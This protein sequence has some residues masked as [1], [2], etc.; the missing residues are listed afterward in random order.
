MSYWPSCS[1][2]LTKRD[3]MCHQE[4]GICPARGLLKC[5]PPKENNYGAGPA[6]LV[7]LRCLAMCPSPDPLLELLKACRLFLLCLSLPSWACALQSADS[8]SSCSF[9]VSDYVRHHADG[10]PTGLRRD[11]LS[12]QCKAYL[13][14][15]GALPEPQSDIASVLQ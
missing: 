13:C 1:L 2:V 14:E 3:E 7:I 4:R 11:W 6:C 9:N 5:L 12:H 15:T 10:T 8:I